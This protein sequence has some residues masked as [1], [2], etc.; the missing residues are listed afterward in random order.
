MF[1][2]KIPILLILL[3]VFSSVSFGHTYISEGEIIVDKPYK[4]FHFEMNEKVDRNTVN[5]SNA[6]IVGINARIAFRDSKTISL[7]PIEKYMPG[8]RY[9]V[10]LYDTIKSQNGENLDPFI[11]SFVYIKDSEPTSKGVFTNIKRRKESTSKAEEPEPKSKM[12]RVAF[13]NFYMNEVKVMA[14]EDGSSAIPPEPQEIDG[15]TFDRWSYDYKNIKEDIIIYPVYSEDP[16]EISVK[17]FVEGIIL[18]TFTII[19]GEEVPEPNTDPTKEGF[20]FK[21]WR[22]KT[23]K[24]E[25]RFDAVFKELIKV[26]Y[27]LDGNIYKVFFVEDLNSSPAPKT[28][29]IKVGYEFNGWELKDGSNGT[30]YEPVFEEIIKEMTVTY[31][32][33]GIKVKSYTIIEGEEIPVPEEIPTKKGYTFLAWKRLDTQGDIQFAAVFEDTHQ[34]SFYTH[35]NKLLKEVNISDGEHPEPPVAPVR[36]GYTFIGWD[37]DFD[38]ITD[39]TAIYAEYKVDEN[40]TKEPAVNTL[41][42]YEDLDKYEKITWNILEGSNKF[43]TKI[44]LGD[45]I[46]YSE[47]KNNVSPLIN[48]RKNNPR[49][50]FTMEMPGGYISEIID[51]KYKDTTK[52]EYNSVVRTL[53]TISEGFN[54]T[55]ESNREK[56]EIIGKYL[57]NKFSYDTGFTHSGELTG[58]TF[59]A[60][61]RNSTVCSGYTYTYKYLLEKQGIRS[62]TVSLNYVT[63]SG[64]LEPHIYNK[65]YLDHDEIV[66][67]DLTH[68]DR[69]T[70]VEKYINNTNLQFNEPN[71]RKI[72][73]IT[74]SL[75]VQ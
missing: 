61:T 69:D 36:K 3:L 65:I 37:Y 41:R 31:I 45:S 21:G 75:V 44:S 63:D 29:P 73:A 64:S 33:R 5:K 6:K 52:A 62:D 70:V 58:Q 23:S 74:E 15:Y 49:I 55:N 48:N 47:Y 66:Y 54:F 1:K 4:I 26:K 24:N 25:M 60:I 28:N 32:S 51:V 16:K 22:K 59:Y 72:T 43:Q 35:D 8:E 38:N 56:S 7:I 19:E 2:R 27:M 14:V 18:E 20:E 9:E 46:T 71:K 68:A 39:D 30:I 50:R 12:F 17:Y 67:T 10:R 13:T 42:W 53:D 11:Q 57:M 40:H 34:I